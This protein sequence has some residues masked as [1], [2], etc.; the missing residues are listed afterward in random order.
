MRRGVVWD[1]RGPR[2]REGRSVGGAG[3]AP[4]PRVAQRAR[5]AARDRRGHRQDALGDV[6]PELL[7]P[8][9]L[10]GRGQTGRRRDDGRDDG[11]D[12]VQHGPRRG[13]LHRRDGG[14]VRLHRSRGR[15]RLAEPGHPVP[16]GGRLARHFPPL[17][18]GGV[19]RDGPHVPREVHAALRETPRGLRQRHRRPG[20]SRVRALADREIHRPREADGHHVSSVLSLRFIVESFPFAPSPLSPRLLS[21]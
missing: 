8:L 5:V 20:R 4:D 11:R 19:R 15:V 18:H 2:P 21:C 12:G 13:R 1:R 6:R 16:H 10:R 7:L 3:V 17:G 9:R 14:R